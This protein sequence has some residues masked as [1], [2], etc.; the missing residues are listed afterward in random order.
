MSKRNGFISIIDYIQ[1]QDTP[2]KTISRNIFSS[3]SDLKSVKQEFMQNFAIV[4]KRSNWVALYHE[5]LSLPSVIARRGTTK[6]SNNPESI[7]IDLADR[8]LEQRATNCLAYGKVHLDTD[9]PHI[10][11][12]I[13]ANP[14]KSPKKHRITKSTFASIKRDLERYKR[15]TY[16]HLTPVEHSPPWEVKEKNRALRITRGERERNRR[17][18]GKDPSKKEIIIEKL[19]EALSSSMSQKSFIA[20]LRAFQLGFYTRGKSHGVQDTATGRKYRLKTLW[21]ID[22]YMGCSRLWSRGVQ[23]KR[24]V[25]NIEAEKWKIFWKEMWFAEEIK[26]ALSSDPAK[27]EK[28]PL[29]NN[30]RL[31]EISETVRSKYYLKRQRSI[32]RN[33]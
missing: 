17:T 26:S 20:R 5:I 8:Y 15:L 6:Q 3:E 11:L 9:N 30:V 29:I 23:R 10:H 24:E 31:N 25:E 21:L 27:L 14:R 22:E 7:L 2:W 33:I 13:S 16:P 1:K 12:I 19:T 18:K 32:S 4:P 28:N